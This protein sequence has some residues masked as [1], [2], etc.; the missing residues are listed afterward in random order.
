MIKP[1]SGHVLINGIELSAFNRDE[2]YT[3]VTA[4]FQ[5]VCLLPISISQ[6]ITY[7][8]DNEIDKERLEKCI[9]LADLKDKIE[10]LPGGVDT[11]LVASVADNGVN[12][13][14]GEIQKLAL[15]RALYK[16][17]PLIV[18]DEPTAALDPIAENKMYLKY[19]E[20]T[21]NKTSIYISHRLSSTRFCDKIIFIDN[22][23]IIEEGTHDELLALGGKYFEM[24]HVQSEYYKSNKEAEDL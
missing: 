1:I 21:Q 22:G 13:S 16:D 5:N 17:A 4:V 20:L 7:E 23:K 2:Y 10:T 15:A 11:D 6:N 14:G 19:N 18:L 8:S 24:F 3:L 9:K 12:L